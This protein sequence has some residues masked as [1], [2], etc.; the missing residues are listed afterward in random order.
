MGFFFKSKANNRNFTESP[1]SNVNKNNY[2]N[3]LV[4]AISL[5]KGDAD[6]RENLS[7]P[8]YDLAEIREAAEA[9]SYIK[10]SIMKYSY[11]LFKAGYLLKSENEKATDYIKTRLY[12]MSFSTGKPVDI[13]FQEIG[14]DLIKYSNAFIIK[15][16]V[17]NIMDGVQAKGFY[18]DNPIGGYFKIDPATVS[19]QRGINGEIKKYIQQ[20]D[21]KEKIYD[22]TEVIHFYLDKEASNAF[23]TPRMLAAMED[24]K[25]LRRIEGNIMTLIHRFS[26]PLFQWIIGKPLTG[27]QATDREIDEAKREIESMPLDGSVVTNEKTEIKAIGAQGTALNASAYLTYFENRVFSALGVSQSQ[28][29]RGATGSNADTMESQAH[30]TVKYIQKIFSIFL[31]NFVINELLLEGGFNPVTNE[32]DRVSFVFN[33]I[34][35]DTRIKLEN[36]EM[37]KFQSNMI[38]FEEMRREIGKKETVDEERLYQNMIIGKAQEDM[39]NVQTDASVEIAQEQGDIQMEQAKFNA[40]TALKTAKITADA[41]AKQAAVAAKSKAVTGSGSKGVNPKGNGTSKSSKPNKSISNTN[42]PSNQHGKTSVKI[43]ES[44]SLQEKAKNSK[45]KHKKSFESVYIKYNNLRNDIID[46]PED[47][48]LIFPLALTNLIEEVKLNMQLYSL[49]GINKATDDIETLQNKKLILPTVRITLMQ[50]EDEARI[51]LQKT[52]QDIKKRIKDDTSENHVN[53]VF[54]VLEYRVRYLLEYILPK[55]YWYS[56]LKTGEAFKYQEAYV[57]FGDSEDSKQ[58]NKTIEL[59]AINVDE[60]PP[61]HSF[62]SCKITFKKGAK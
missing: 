46:N 58:Y 24:V 52:L 30:D 43:K 13:L 7:A 50:F 48:D 19:V 6:T 17:K 29:G 4:K 21:G 62:C 55:V 14:D 61:F 20:V 56:Y 3:Y 34:S 41:Q 31:E 51:T 11:M 42:T 33:E 15:S 57:D 18:K 25:I 8:E 27:F 12:I 32:D 60:I 44:L 9:D 1:S 16:R 5:I 40:D 53:D 38:T 28:M 10:M 39:I 45:T 2:K 36:H 35:I 47:I 59:K 54:D 49:E 26:M 37:N 22:V 23:G